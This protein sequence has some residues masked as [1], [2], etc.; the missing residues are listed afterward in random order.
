MPPVHQERSAQRNTARCAATSNPVADLSR[1]SDDLAAAKGLVGAWGKGRDGLV[2][3][4]E[5]NWSRAC[6]I[7]TQFGYPTTT[8]MLPAQPR[9][10]TATPPQYQYQHYCNIHSTNVYLIPF[11]PLSTS[12]VPPIPLSSPPVQPPLPQ[13]W[14]SPSSAPWRTPCGTCGPPSRLPGQPSTA[15]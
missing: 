2:R 3:A 12:T 15:T 9:H 8:S 13:Q 14:L 6:V 10:A 11:P 1:D 4:G 5:W 7:F